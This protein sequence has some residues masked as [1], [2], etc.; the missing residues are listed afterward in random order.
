MLTPLSTAAR[1]IPPG[2]GGYNGGASGGYNGGGYD[3]W[4]DD[5]P[6]PEILSVSFESSTIRS[7]HVAVAKINC[8]GATPDEVSCHP[9]TPGFE[10]QL[11]E[12]RGIVDGRIIV[13]LRIHR[14]IGAMRRLCLIR[15]AVGGASAVASIT[16]LH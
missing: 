8:I 15:F 13:G 11:L 6:R 7:D 3:R 2:G 10:V 4:D 5:P 9:V 16:V 12:E 14:R 1:S